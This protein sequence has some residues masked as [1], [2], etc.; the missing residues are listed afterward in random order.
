MMAQ[1]NH[2]DFDDELLSAYVDGELTAT[3]R[4]LVEERL[5]SDPAAAAL[6]EELRSLSSAIKALPQQTLGRDLRA[7]VLAELD[8]ARADLAK[9]GP[10]TLP[11]A[12]I[13]RRAGMRRGLIWSAMAI[14]AALLVALFQPAEIEQNE[15]ELARAEQDKPHESVVT[16]E[17]TAAKKAASQEPRTELADAEIVAEQRDMSDHLAAAPAPPA[18]D[19]LPPGLQGSMGLPQDGMAESKGVAL[20]ELAEQPAAPPMAP[21][22]MTQ[23][24]EA[25]Q[26]AANGAK[27]AD[28]SLDSK[29]AELRQAEP[30]AMVE[31][32]LERSASMAAPEVEKPS[33][34]A[35]S[36]P[37]STSAPASATVPMAGLGG[38]GGGAGPAGQATTSAA[39]PTVAGAPMQPVNRFDAANANERQVT[40]KLAT[41]EGVTRFRQLLAESEILPADE[42]L[43]RRQL[44]GRGFRSS[45]ADEGAEQL[46]DAKEKADKNAEIA[47][48]EQRSFYFSAEGERFGSELDRARGGEEMSYAM[49]GQAAGK[50]G[51][52]GPAADA[53]AGA[54]PSA[55]L[56]WV[57][58]TPAELEA[59]LEKLR[60]AKE[61]F[62]TVEWSETSP[63]ASTLAALGT[64]LKAEDHARTKSS[65]LAFEPQATGDAATNGRERV[66]FVLE[67]ATKQPE[68][69]APAAAEPAVQ[70]AK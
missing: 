43:L 55:D 15:R 64:T 9:H 56:V 16:N 32:S 61:V 68:L 70:E 30:G 13:D 39:V 35:A 2:D 19:S 28:A 63:Q 52:G 27:D 57:E 37:A 45:A 42:I 69:A 33:I 12:P 65:S 21:A 41:P 8:E 20:G 49:R 66:L 14:A 62:A 11:T 53:P 67:P 60:T 3:E 40:L 54:T 38:A 48:T 36:A 29:F 59:L 4:A 18:S 5:R 46:A 23:D 17:P 1:T 31:E 24:L 58:A 51:A 47:S 50:L 44:A 7:G 10:T 26:L 25:G 22:P 6:V 34:A